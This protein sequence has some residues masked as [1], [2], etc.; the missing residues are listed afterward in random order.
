M[1]YHLEPQVE[2]IL[3][4][5]EKCACIMGTIEWPAGMARFHNGAGPI[6]SEGETY[7][8]V[9]NN[10][11]VS[12][13]KEGN[14]PRVTL[15]LITPDTSVLAEALKDDAAG[16]EVRLYLGVFNDDQQLVA[17][18]LIYLGIVNN[19]P[20]KYS[21]PPTI[22]VECVSYTHRW[23]QPKR[24]TTYSAASQRAIYPNDSFLDDVEAVAKG[25]LSSYSGSNAVSSGGRSGSRAS[26]TKMR[27]V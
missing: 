25:P 2:A 26:T 21:A 6:K 27:A 8:G 7:W 5:S 16:G 12:V 11:M 23:S 1:T 14:A 15:T 22:S 20:A 3:S 18:Q 4:Q 17:K 24:Y 13:I 10:G 19:T 9:A